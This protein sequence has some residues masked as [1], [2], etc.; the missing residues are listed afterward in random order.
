MADCMAFNS[1]HKNQEMPYF[2]QELMEQS[3]A[4]GDLTQPEYLDA[5][6]NNQK[7][8]RTQ[9][10]DTLVAQHQLDAIVAPTTGPAWMTI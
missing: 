4:K 8:S 1:A 9:G 3:Q 6:A 7:L 2:G 5:L 10:I